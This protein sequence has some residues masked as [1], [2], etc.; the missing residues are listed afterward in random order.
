MKKILVIA[1]TLIVT[2]GLTVPAF[3]VTTQ[4]DIVSDGVAPIVKCKWETPDDADALHEIPGTQVL[5]NAGEVIND[6]ACELSIGTKQVQYWAVVTHPVAMGMV[7]GVYADIF[8]PEALQQVNLSG[9]PAGTGEWCGSF[10]YQ[11]ELTPYMTSDNL[12]QVAAFNQAMAEDL[13]TIASP[14]TPEDIIDELM[15]G[16][17]ELYMGI[18]D[19][20]NHQPAGDYTVDVSAASGS[21]WSPI[22]TNTLVFAE[23]NS[24]ILDF[25]SVNYG[26]VAVGFEKQVGGDSNMCTPNKPTVWNNGNTYIN[27]NVA[28]ND[29]GF[30]QRSVGGVSVW[31]VHWAAR[32]GDEQD[33]TK[34]SYDPNQAAVTLPELLV[35][36]TPTKLD[37]FILVDKAPTGD[38]TYG[39]TMTIGS[40]IVPF[41]PCTQ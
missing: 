20:H 29:A 23:L 38:G 21:S 22:V 5:A 33:G 15:Q 24:F 27:L 19:I 34:V 6:G 9:D 18:E 2:L 12:A 35:M 36:C 16:E 32:L 37:F 31:N 13:V 26:Q 28:Q 7:S 4:V 8:H 30:G 17:A 14:Y 10:K 40:D 1:I 41:I 39:G 11:V 3:A 25:E